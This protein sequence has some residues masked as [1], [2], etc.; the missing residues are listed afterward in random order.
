MKVI[1]TSQLCNE[2]GGNFNSSVECLISLVK[3]I[4][5]YHCMGTDGSYICGE[6]SMMYGE[7]ESLCCTP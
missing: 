4:Y 1:T 7:G 6:H 2:R 3:F 5:F